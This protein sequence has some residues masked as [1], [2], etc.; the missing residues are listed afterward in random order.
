M[1]T[2]DDKQAMSYAYKL[3]TRKLPT[4]LTYHSLTHTRDDVVPAVERLANMMGVGGEDLVLLRTAACFHDTGFVEQRDEH[5]AAS[6]RIAARILPRF[7]YTSHQIRAIAGMIM[8]TRLPQTPRTP[9][10]QILA[11]ADLD[12]LG[13]A[14]FLRTSQAL[15]SEL[16]AFGADISEAAW[17]ERQ[18][19][20]LGSHR[21]FTPA[22]C[23]LRDAGKRRNIALL[24]KLI[25]AGGRGLLRF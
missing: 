22:A 20:F 11:D 17:Y 23:T 5:E 10:E 16:A 6:A 9:L 15:R 21:Y 24:E 4:T 13:R 8:A 3:L 18:L 25:S 7:G 12:S 14:D 2:P 1:G 19:A